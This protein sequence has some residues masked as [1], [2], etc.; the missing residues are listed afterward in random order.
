MIDAADV[1]LRVP[2]L[3]EA[4]L[5]DSWRGSPVQE[6]EFNDFGVL[7]TGSVVDDVRH[8]RVVDQHGGTLVVQHAGEVVGAVTWRPV[9]YGPNR[10]SGA[11]D[12]G[13]ALVP[14]ARGR[15]IGTT[16]QRLLAE[17]LFQSTP[18][19]RVQ[20]STDVENVA[21]QRALEKAG[22]VREGVARQAQYR[23]GAYHDLVTYAVLRGEV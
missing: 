4:A 12:I 13:V 16:A 9:A 15:G 8:G 22:F 17:Y 7:P 14:E 18:V 19:H 10:E 11:L 23:A 20:A 3:S 2:A 1:I 21:E 5:L 6:G